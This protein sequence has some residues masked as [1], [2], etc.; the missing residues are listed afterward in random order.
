MRGKLTVRCNECKLLCAPRVG[1][2]LC[3]FVALAVLA[4]NT[5]IGLFA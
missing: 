2:A 3:I 5:L 1:A 4:V